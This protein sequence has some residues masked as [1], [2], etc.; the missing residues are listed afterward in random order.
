[1][2]N[3]EYKEGARGVLVKA[4][5]NLLHVRFQG[6]IR[7]GEVGMVQL[8]GTS[9]KAEVIEIANDIAKLQVFEDIRGVELN[10]P[11]VFTSHLLE[12]ELGPGLMSMIFDG[13]QNPLEQV[14]QVSGLFFLKP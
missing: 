6:H 1:M 8:D 12:A 10:T 14:A 3:Q 13:L 5:G 2:E 4:F 9:L 11:I 7:Q